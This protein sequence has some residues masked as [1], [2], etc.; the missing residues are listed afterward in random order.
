MSAKKHSGASNRTKE[1][2]GSSHGACCLRAALGFRADLCLGF[3]SD[4]NASRA[5]LTSSEAR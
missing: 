1:V 3:F 5:L 4:S 2:G